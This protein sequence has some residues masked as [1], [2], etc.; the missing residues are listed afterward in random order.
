M[1][2]YSFKQSHW[3]TSSHW[4]HLFC[5]KGVIG[6]QSWSSWWSTSR[7]L[8]WLVPHPHKNLIVFFSLPMSIFCRT[9]TQSQLLILHQKEWSKEQ[10]WAWW[11][12]LSS[13]VSNDQ[14]HKIPFFLHWQ[15]NILLPIDLRSDTRLT[16]FNFFDWQILH[17]T[18]VLTIVLLWEIFPVSQKWLGRSLLDSTLPDSCSC[19]FRWTVCTPRNS[20]ESNHNSDLRESPSLALTRDYFHTRTQIWLF[21]SLCQC[22]S[23][24][25]LG[26]S[27]SFQFCTNI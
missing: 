17:S 26:R 27:R 15:L 7:R 24:A 16:L 4:L 18:F 2:L 12:S 3:S 10:L 11:K 22:P 8:S 23:S 21:F 20:K 6:L 13:S 1:R 5:M 14:Q 25:R 19:L 9:W